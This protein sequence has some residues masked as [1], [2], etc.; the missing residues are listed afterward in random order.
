MKAAQLCQAPRSNSFK[1]TPQS[2]C[3]QDAPSRSG[4]VLVACGDALGARLFRNEG[5]MKSLIAR[6]IAQVIILYSIIVLPCY[7]QD[8]DFNRELRNKKHIIVE[9]AVEGFGD[10][11]VLHVALAEGAGRGGGG[12][13]SPPLNISDY[14]FGLSVL[15][16]RKASAI[17]SL[18][19]TLHFVDGTE[20][21]IDERFLVVQGEKKEYQF[22]YGVKIKSYFTGRRGLRKGSRST[23]VAVP[24]NS[25][26][27]TRN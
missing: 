19:M 22:A 12:G 25:F 2:R 16:L 3:S 5:K 27:P 13:V 21:K 14:T 18:T 1:R 23:L 15:E 7:S 24:N 8:A 6:R 20:K 10:S 26:N 17:L 9:L 4:D 11:S